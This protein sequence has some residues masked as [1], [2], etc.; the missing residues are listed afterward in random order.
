MKTLEWERL[1]DRKRDHA[2]ARDEM[3]PAQHVQ[4][5]VAEVQRHADREAELE[6]KCI[7]LR[8]RLSREIERNDALRREL[9]GISGAF[10]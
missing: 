4:L 2:P 7:E 9:Q 10:R 1:Q 5:L 3:T 8:D 6:E